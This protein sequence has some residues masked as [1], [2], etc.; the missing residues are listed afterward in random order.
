MAAGK[1]RLPATSTQ[2]RDGC[3]WSSPIT[4]HQGHTRHAAAGVSKRGWTKECT[5]PQCFEIKEILLFC[6]TKAD[7]FPLISWFIRLRSDKDSSYFIDFPPIKSLQTS[8]RMKTRGII[9]R[10]GH[11]TQVINRVLSLEDKCPS[12]DSNTNQWASTDTIKPL[13]NRKCKKKPVSL[14]LMILERKVKRFV[15]M[16]FLHQQKEPGRS[17]WIILTYL[18]CC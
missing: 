10:V 13:T 3:L 17:G 6:G 2:G 9:Y 11:N 14:V 8:G 5:T 7:S 15:Y 16:D 1:A 4:H 12:S 18:S